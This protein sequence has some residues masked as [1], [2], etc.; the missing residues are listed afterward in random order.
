M[1]LPAQFEAAVRERLDA[2]EP[3]L[4]FY[5]TPQP[6]FKFYNLSRISL[7]AFTGEGWLANKT[8]WPTD[9]LEKVVA[10][11]MRIPSNSPQAYETT[12]F[13]QAVPVVRELVKRFSL[14]NSDQ[15]KIMAN[16]KRN[17]L[18]SFQASCDWLK[19]RDNEKGWKRW[20]PPRNNDITLAL[21]LPVSDDS[22]LTTGWP[23]GR[24][25]AGAAELAIRTVN[26]DSNLLV[27]QGAK[28]NLAYEWKD[29]SCSPQK[30]LE[31]LGQLT[32]TVPATQLV[33]AIGPAC[34]TACEVTAYLLA[35]SNLPQISF[36]CTAAQL[37]D[38]KRYPL[39]SAHCRIASNLF[40]GHEK[41]VFFC[42]VCTHNC[43][44][45]HEGAVI[46]R[47]HAAQQLE[48]NCDP[49]QHRSCLL[50]HRAQPDRPGQKCR[51]GSR[52]V[53]FWG[54]RSGGCD[55][56]SQRNQELRKTSRS[57][58]GFREG[59]TSHRRRSE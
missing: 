9:V 44:R 23:I 48:P 58:P 43:A 55:R 24:R 57:G 10:R 52:T 19:D 18:S 41:V 33:G 21:L 31:G 14:T 56:E 3:T 30:A 22:R 28:L 13:A 4:F 51:L 35:G 16:I 5:W 11:Q 42:A 34:S 38:K 17:N 37:S 54:K 12:D 1:G 45:N 25:I 29:S 7:P 15:V 27:Y 20:I 40:L 32:Q 49:L 50:G 8:D 39:V 53:D 47:F 2:K 6:F 59:Y 26:N 46:D 36:G